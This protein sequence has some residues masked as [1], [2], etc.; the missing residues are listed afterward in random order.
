MGS[1]NSP[2]YDECQTQVCKGFG[3]AMRMGSSR[4]LERVLMAVPKP[5]QTEF[6]IHHRLDIC[7]AILIHR[8]FFALLGLHFAPYGLEAS[9][10]PLKT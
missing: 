1:H 3:T 6:D 10:F 4:Q 2:I 5:M 8:I 9:A 7:A